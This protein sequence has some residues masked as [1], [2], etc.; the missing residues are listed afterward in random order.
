MSSSERMP[1]AYPTNAL[2]RGLRLIQLVRDEGRIRVTDAAEELG[3]AASSA[4]RL[5]QTLVYRDYLVQDE[6]HAYVPGPAMSAGAAGIAWSRGLRRTAAPHMSRLGELVGNSTNLAIRVRSEV[7]VLASA[8]VP[9][10]TYDWRGSVLPAHRTASGKAMLSLLADPDLERMY[11]AEGVNTAVSV[12]EFDRLMDGIGW[13]RRTGWSISKGECERTI[14][15]IGIPIRSRSGAPLGAMT[16]TTHGP[17]SLV[18][19]GLDRTV[20]YMRQACA[21]IEAEIEGDPEAPAP[22]EAIASTA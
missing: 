21:R 17:S 3:V 12:A 8:T 4:H 2:D 5:L 19:P 20:R 13:V 15:A 14:T 6:T 1:P 10:S 7:R 11:L 22:G 16:I 9:G 18:G